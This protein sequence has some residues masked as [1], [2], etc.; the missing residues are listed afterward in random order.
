VDAGFGDVGLLDCRESEL[1]MDLSGE[2]MGEGTYVPTAK[3][4]SFVPRS[5]AAMVARSNGFGSSAH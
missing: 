4:Y 2:R 5:G 3:Y 1:A